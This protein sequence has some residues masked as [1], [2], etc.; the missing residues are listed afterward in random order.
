LFD[1]DARPLI[2]ST[3]AILA[4]EML[5]ALA[6]R[7]PA[8]LPGW[9]YDQVDA[10]L[11]DGRVAMAAA[12]PG[13]YGAIAAS[14]L[15][16]RLR[17]APYVSGRARRVS[18]AGCHSWAIPVTCDDVDAAADLIAALLSPAAARLEASSGAVCAHVK[19]FAE[20]C[21][22][23]DVDVLRLEITRKT[24]EDGVITY[25][26]LAQFPAVEDAGWSAINAA[27]RGELTATEAVDAMQR[28]ADEALA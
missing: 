7:A 28:A 24:I 20:V 21:P 23:D 27:L 26:P 12:W 8:D 14:E 22:R 13:A 3:E 16:D 15:Y 1:D 4:V 10:A 25:P 18:Y 19:E 9:H 6:R 2:R 11:L 5:C 17:P